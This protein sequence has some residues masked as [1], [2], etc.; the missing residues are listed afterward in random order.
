M[1][2]VA[3]G[4]EAGDGRRH[5]VPAAGRPTFQGDSDR[6]VTAPPNSHPDQRENQEDKTMS[7]LRSRGSGRPA[8]GL[9]AAVRSFPAAL[10][11][12][13]ATLA[14]VSLLALAGCGEE[15]VA[16]GWT[17]QEDTLANGT[18]RVVNLPPPD[19]IEPRW[20]V[21]EELRIGTMDA[22]GP[23]TFGEV[24]AVA[25]TDDGRIAVLDAG[26][27][28][29]RIFGPDGAHLH[30]FGGE[31]QGPGEL[32]NA[33]GMVL[34]PDGLLRVND[35]RNARLSFFHPDSGFVRSA[36]LDIQSWGYIWE[37]AVD[38]TGRVYE[39][40]SAMIDEERWRV[41][42]VYD[43]QGRWSDTIPLSTYEIDRSSDPPGAYRWQSGNRG[44]MV[45]VPFFPGGARALDPRGFFWAKGGGTNDYR[46][47]RTTF[48]GDTTLVFESRRPPEPVSGQERDS[49]VSRIREITGGQEL[50]WS[51]IPAEKPVLRGIFLDRSGRPWV[52]VTA[53][54]DTLVAYD[55]FR[56][57]GHYEGTAVT[58][59]PVAPYR[60]PVVRDD[61]FYTVVTDELDVPYVVR[62]RIREAG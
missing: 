3:T 39:V 38:S 33:N 4:A 26:A 42:K 13:A 56:R 15:A 57:D 7:P 55:V 41:V 17:V 24:K 12:P 19:G 28:E 43:A 37:G 45:G 27:Q 46:I 34:G 2:S 22:E 14:G 20:V 61:L 9:P 32:S 5:G 30:T 16:S 60:N 53:P 54:G 23:T 10:A 36:P 50:D 31:G 29:I 40:N 52:R 51:R 62:A 21:E 47:A 58:S 25:V 1:E 59:L 18:P 48:Q 6:M 44:G 35:P 49:A 11:G 8:T